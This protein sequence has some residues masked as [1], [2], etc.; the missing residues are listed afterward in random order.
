M[1]EPAVGPERLRQLLDEGRESPQ[2]AYRRSVVLGT[3]GTLSRRSLVELARDIGAMQARGGHI[4]IGSDEHG[5]PVGDLGGDHAAIEQAFDGSALR[6]SLREWI[7][8]PVDVRCAVHGIAGHSLVLLHIGA[9]PDGLC[10][11]RAIGR[12]RDGIVFRAGEVFVRQG[13][14]S[15]RWTQ[16]DVAALVEHAVAGRKDT[17]RREMRELFADTPPPGTAPDRAGLTWRLDR[18][19]FEELVMEALRADDH[20][21]LRRCLAEATRDAQALAGED[22]GG[23]EFLTV[24]DRMAQAAAAGVTYGR[25][26][27]LRTAADAMLRVHR[28]TRS[29][30][31]VAERMTAV[32]ALAVRWED[33]DA[34]RELLLDGGDG[35]EASWVRH[36]L[37]FVR[38]D[39]GHERPTPILPL[40][41]RL[42]RTRECLRPDL[43]PGDERILDSLCQFAFLA[44]LS[45]VGANESDARRFSTGFAR[46]SS[47]RTEPIV[48]RLLLDRDLRDA[49]SPLEDAGLARA[50]HA[51]DGMA[52]RESF[53]PAGW[54]G[55]GHDVVRR[56]LR[57]HGDAQPAPR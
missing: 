50:L 35:A 37:A 33:W 15:R 45:L 20:F 39:D 7:P 56:F 31:D 55:Y 19:T 8:D 3:V 32:G 46:Y 36:A 27:L 24:L 2:L 43:A 44:G 9:R 42:I 25:G 48:V 11:F 28:T 21:T 38:D 53:G 23:D 22:G 12:H 51:L 6:R 34:V 26:H 54:R 10:V 1:S 13:A 14:S 30:R 29:A 57:K 4:V 41:A 5:N 18:E 49:V 52:K 47:D 17:W 40:A 16:E